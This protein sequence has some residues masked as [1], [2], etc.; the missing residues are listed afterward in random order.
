MRN[1]GDVLPRVTVAI[2]AYNRTDLLRESIESVL[3]QSY[4]DLRLLVIDDCSTADVEP[5][6]R[7][8]EDERIVYSRNEKNL[9]LVGNWN[10]AFELCDTEYLNV[11][12]DDDRMFPWMVDY[13][14]SALDRN[15]SAGLALSSEFCIMDLSPRPVE[16]ITRP[17]TIYG[18]NQFIEEYLRRGRNFMVCPSAMFR[19]SYVDAEEMRFCSDVGLCADLFFWVEANARGVDICS[20]N[21]P[22]LEYRR[23][24]G[25][26]TNLSGAEKWTYTHKRVEEYILD[27]GL[28]CDMRRMRAC[29]AY[30]VVAMAAYGIR[31]RAGYERV[32]E[33]RRYLEREMNWRMEDADFH[34][35]VA[36]LAWEEV[37]RRRG[38]ETVSFSEYFS[39]LRELREI[40]AELPLARKFKWFVRYVLQKRR[41]P[42]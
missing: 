1:G 8:Y 2:C 38:Y 12:H 29:A 20:V 6:V 42:R 24:P 19:M 21:Q 35:I 17:D 4:H 32:L 31:D 36:I 28:N 3:N 25:S 22:L 9:G 34:D 10:R 23:H 14:V 11:F 37:M 7:S 26:C 27:L 16:P 41:F 18:K 13:L 5:L 33:K 40:V 39:L 15:P 30:D